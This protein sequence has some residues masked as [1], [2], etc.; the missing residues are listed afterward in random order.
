MIT[1]PTMFL[2]DS[3]ASLVTWHVGFRPSMKASL[4]QEIRRILDLSPEVDGETENPN[5]S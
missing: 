2:L 1:L 4:E 3:D 5:E